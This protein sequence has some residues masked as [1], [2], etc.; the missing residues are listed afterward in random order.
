MPKNETVF[1]FF[2]DAREEAEQVVWPT[3]RDWGISRL[4][5]ERVVA[6]AS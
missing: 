1:P 6:P 3:R 2:Q 4:V 5:G